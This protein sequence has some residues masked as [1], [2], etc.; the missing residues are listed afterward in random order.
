MKR[1]CVFVAV[2]F[3][4]FAAPAVAQEGTPTLQ[5]GDPV[6]ERANIRVTPGGDGAGVVEQITVSNAERLGGEVE[7]ILTRFEGAGDVE[8]LAVTAGGRELEVEREEGGVVDRLLVPLPEGTSGEFGYEV[9]YRYAG[10]SERVPLVVP[11]IPTM[12]DA[13]SIALELVVPEGRY[14]R[15]SFPV[16]ESGDSGT[17][18]TDMIGFPNYTSFVLGSSPV[19]VFTRSNAYTALALVVIVGCIA[20]IFL[21]DRRFA[22][23]TETKEA[24]N[25]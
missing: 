4:S 19:G 18:S 8:D 14:L 24:T 17:V 21:Y 25:V 11:A 5:E 6:V 10:G 13:N 16:I 20:G 3:L 2:V 12:G 15:D 9:S 7:H 22:K 23:I 1:V